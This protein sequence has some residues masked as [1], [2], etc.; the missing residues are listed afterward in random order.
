MKK[1]ISL[2]LTLC[3]LC[4]GAALAEAVTTTEP[5]TL[6]LEGFTLTLGV[7]EVY[8]QT[9]KVLNQ[10]YLIVFPFAGE[11][12][13]TTCYNIIWNGKPGEAIMD[14]LKIQYPEKMEDNLRSEFEPLGITVD[15]VNMQTPAD[16]MLKDLRCVVFDYSADLSLAGNTVTFFFRQIYIGS[17]ATWITITTDSEEKVEQTAQ[18]LTEGLNFQ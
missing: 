2:I 9:E 5:I 8:Q 17:I 4:T 13:N 12:D 7:G 3:L 1:M 6:E 14:E 11:G 16:A 15:A 18:H 10:P